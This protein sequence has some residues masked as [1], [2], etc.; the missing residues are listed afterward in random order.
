[1]RYLTGYEPVFG[2]H[3]VAYCLIVPGWPPTLLAD[4]FWDNPAANARR[5]AHHQ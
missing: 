3:D 1:M 4:A 5:R 2:L